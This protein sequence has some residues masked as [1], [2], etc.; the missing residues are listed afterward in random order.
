MS[1]LPYHHTIHHQQPTYIIYILYKYH[2][3]LK[4][5]EWSQIFWSL[6]DSLPIQVSHTVPLSTNDKLF[7][8]HRTMTFKFIRGYRG[9]WCYFYWFCPPLINSMWLD[10]SLSPIIAM[11]ASTHHPATTQYNTCTADYRTTRSKQ[12][13]Q[14]T[15]ERFSTTCKT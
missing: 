10:V 4:W 12:E 6:F 5:C 11:I 9:I 7:C 14:H 3:R 15:H 13:I 1:R 8:T 2:C